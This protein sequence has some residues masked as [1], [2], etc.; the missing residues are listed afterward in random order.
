MK[1]AFLNCSFCPECPCHY[2]SIRLVTTPAWKSSASSENC[3][4]HLGR[5]LLSL[6]CATSIVLL[7]SVTPGPF[8]PPFLEG[9]NVSMDL[10]P[11]WILRV[12]LCIA[13]T[14]LCLPAWLLQSVLWISHNQLD[15][16]RRVDATLL[17]PTSSQSPDCPF[18][19]ILAE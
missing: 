13:Q 4:L 6:L 14:S 9:F 15:I 10:L 19:S 5:V 7:L 3:P 12:Q 16:S 11:G 8:L 18:G 2:Y 17:Q 1:K